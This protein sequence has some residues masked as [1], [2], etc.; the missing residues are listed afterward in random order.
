LRD[1]I[2]THPRRRPRTSGTDP[3]L[4]RVEMRRRVAVL[5]DATSAPIY[6][7]FNPLHSVSVHIA[8][9]SGDTVGRSQ[10]PVVD[11]LVA[12]GCGVGRVVRDHRR[13]HHLSRLQRNEPTDELLTVHSGSGRCDRDSG[14]R[15]QITHLLVH[16]HVE[17]MYQNVRLDILLEEKTS[18][19][20]SC[21]ITTIRLSDKSVISCSMATIL[22]LLISS[23]FT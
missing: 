22:L 17:R 5:S 21:S 16:R 15:D 4:I 10:D 13:P 3:P 14:R 19:V 11:R 7:L 23:I 8:N 1:G 20:I 9:D 2:T 12:V 18:S 6:P